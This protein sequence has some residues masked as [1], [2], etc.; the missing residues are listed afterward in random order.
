MLKNEHLMREYDL[1][2][3]HRI[4]TGAA[5]L[6]LETAEDLQRIQPTWSILQAYGTRHPSRSWYLGSSINLM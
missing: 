1:G 3:V 5:P 6:G 2:S 4:I